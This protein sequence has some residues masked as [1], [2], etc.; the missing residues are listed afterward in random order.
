MNRDKFFEMVDFEELMSR[1]ESLLPES[2]VE[3]VDS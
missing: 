1:R 2:D 3:Q